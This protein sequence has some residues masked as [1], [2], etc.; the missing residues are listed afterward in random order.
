MNKKLL[1]IFFFSLTIFSFERQR[2][3]IFQVEGVGVKEEIKT[4][5]LMSLSSELTNSKRIINIERSE[6]DKILREQAIQLSGCTSIECQVEVGRMLGAEKVIFGTISK[7][8]EQFLIS[9]KIVDVTLGTIEFEIGPIKCKNVDEFRKI[10]QEI[11]KGIEEKIPVI[12]EIV[13]FLGNQPVLDVGRNLGIQVGDVFTVLRIKDVVKNKEGRVIF[14]NEE[15][16]GKIKVVSIQEDGAVCEIIEKTKDLVKGD[17]SRKGDISG[18]KAG[19]TDGPSI[20]HTPVKFA[21]SNKPLMIKAKV[22][23]KSGVKDVI[24]N[25][26]TEDGKIF[27]YEMKR[28][29]KETYSLS[30]PKDKLKFY[31]LYY[32]IEATDIN[33]NR[34]LLNDNGNPFEVNIEQVKGSKK[35][36]Y[37]I[38]GS[39]VAAGV[40]GGATYF[41]L[42]N[43]GTELPGLPQ[44]P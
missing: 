39:A 27:K 29:D 17:I 19:D 16:I 1:L 21:K 25:I 11:V 43:T 8:E 10:S 38:I 23:D 37:I 15:V 28:E 7:V 6:I 26:K 42:R 14:R 40:G 13:G 36:L 34:S 20:I 24:I 35:P 2:I 44:R 4:A 32:E 33:G 41:I 3:A 9:A 22:N 12:P 18:I 30:V 5:L 31:R